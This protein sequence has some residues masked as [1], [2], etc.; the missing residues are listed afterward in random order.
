MLKKTA[1]HGLTLNL[2]SKS[3]LGQL[4]AVSLMTFSHLEAV[5]QLQYSK[6]VD[7]SAW[8]NTEARIVV[9]SDIGD[10][11]ERT[12]PQTNTEENKLRA[13]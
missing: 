8:S 2:G 3:N 13:R 10:E 6:S 5:N 9:H 1:K 4:T 12:N 11:S 7:W